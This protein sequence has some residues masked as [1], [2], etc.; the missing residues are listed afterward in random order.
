[1]TRRWSR[2]PGLFLLL[3]GMALGQAEPGFTPL[4]NGK[5]LD[6]WKLVGGVGPGYVVEG[7]K[8]VCPSDGGGIFSR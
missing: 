6:G 4:F 5:N 7:D 2:F 3:T 1:M 8:I